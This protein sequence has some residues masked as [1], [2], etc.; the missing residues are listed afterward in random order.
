MN[1]FEGC[2]S[3]TEVI[4]PDGIPNLSSGIARCPALERIT[5]SGRVEKLGGCEKRVFDQC[6]TIR[7]SYQSQSCVLG[8]HIINQ[9]NHSDKC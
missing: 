3:L 5:I 6:Y 7:G 9:R 4:V 2:T 1:A 8:L